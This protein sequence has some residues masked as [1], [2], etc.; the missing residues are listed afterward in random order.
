[1]KAVK[2]FWKILQSLL[3]VLLATILL[4][5]LYV[6][7]AKHFLGNNS[8]TVFGFSWAVVLTGSMEPEISGN[9]MVIAKAQEEYAVGDIIMFESGN[10]LIT[11]RIVEETGN[12][13]ITKGDANNTPDSAPVTEESIVGKIVCT[14]PEVGMVLGY[15]KTPLGMT[16]LVLIGFLLIEIPYLL[17]K[18]KTE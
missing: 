14:V 18:R 16:A 13:F 7:A 12:G 3:L 10:S 17:E 1:M 8:P 6:M 2:I 5:N 9:D 4:C 11:H 15:L